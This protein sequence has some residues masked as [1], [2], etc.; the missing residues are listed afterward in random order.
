MSSYHWLDSPS[1][2]CHV[3]ACPMVS[4]SWLLPFLSIPF[5]FPCH[6]LGMSASCSSMYLSLP[7]IFPTS[8]FVFFDF[9]V[10]CVPFIAPL[11]VSFL[12]PSFPFQLPFVSLSFPFAFLFLSPACSCISLLPFFP[13]HVPFIFPA[14]PLRFPFTPRYFFLMSNTSQ[15]F[16]QASCASA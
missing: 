3:P 4:S 6:F 7:V 14:L 16:G 12:S 10:L 5:S 9:L 2:P 8:P 1:C 13:V 11:H 15:N